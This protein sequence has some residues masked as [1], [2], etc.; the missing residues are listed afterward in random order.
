MHGLDRIELTQTDI[1]KLKVDSIVNAAN[2]SLLGGGG[3]DGAIHRAAGPDLL[4]ECR[5]LGGCATGAAKITRGYGLPAKFVIHTVGPV[6]RGGRHQEPEQL[7][8]CYRACFELAH[9]NGLATIAFPAISCGVYGYPLGEA[10]LVA[11][12]ETQAALLARP[13]LARVW[14]ACFTPEVLKAYQNGVTAI[15]EGRP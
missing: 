9:T 6:W 2:N 12:R 10:A 1:T 13:E 8:S 5:A 11:L 14:F 3:V 7:A 4:A 15:Q